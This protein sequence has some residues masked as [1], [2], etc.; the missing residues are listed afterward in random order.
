MPFNQ[1]PRHVVLFFSW[2]LASLYTHFYYHFLSCLKTEIFQENLYC[3]ICIVLTRGAQVAR[4]S[5]ETAL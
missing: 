2:T 4:F 5:Y 3:K 1:L